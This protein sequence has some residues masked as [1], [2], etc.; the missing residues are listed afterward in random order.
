LGDFD[1]T[2]PG[3]V[4]DQDGI[5]VF[6]DSGAINSIGLE[7]EQRSFAFAN[8]PDDDY[9]IIEF[10]IKNKA[11]DT[12]KG[13]YPGLF[14]DWDID[15]SSPENDRVGRDTVSDV[16]MI[17]QYDSTSSAYLTI[18][19]LNHATASNKLIDNQLCLFDG[20]TNE[21]KYLY[22]SGD[23][24]LSSDTASDF[25]AGDWSM[26]SSAGPFI[27]PPQESTTVAFAVVAGS[28]IFDLK[29]NVKAAKIKYYDVRTDVKSN[30]EPL[31]PNSFSLKQNHPNPF[32]PSTTI[33]FQ[34]G[35][36]EHVA[37]RPSHLTLKI[38]NILGQLVR[39]LVDGEKL[40]GRYEVIWDGEDDRGKEVTSGVYFYRLESSGT[41]ETRKMILLR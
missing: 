31:I 19:P 12:L 13:I 35:S 22:L 3:K 39:A 7:I 38:Y 11:A 37:G 16:P 14:F 40:P 27:I 4:S 25:Y 33:P 9:L 28:S 10:T 36:L 24:L 6:S 2:V 17:Y 8:P 29:E 21:E 23:T 32:N 1:I 20:F 18:L 34:A 5:G 30:Q 26:L 15:L 41:T